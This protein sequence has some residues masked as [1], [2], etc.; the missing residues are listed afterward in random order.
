MCTK[1]KIAQSY[2]TPGMTIQYRILSGVKSGKFGMMGGTHLNARKENLS[3]VWEVLLSHRA[4]L[5]VDSFVER[6]VNFG[7]HKKPT[8]LACIF[9]FAGDLAIIT[10][11]SISEVAKVH[12][13]M[14][15]VVED[16]E[17]WLR[18]GVLK[19]ADSDIQQVTI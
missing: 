7:K 15:C 6:G 19:L 11:D 9:D 12:N 8:K 1:L 17:A 13:R 14:P 18:D 3:S 16:E 2:I 4:I 5:E 10:T